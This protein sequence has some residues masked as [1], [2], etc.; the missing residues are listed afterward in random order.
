MEVFRVNR[1]IAHLIVLQRIELAGLF[2]KKLR[3]LF[4]RYIYSNFISKYFININ[5]VGEKYY[6][7]MQNE[8]KKIHNYLKPG[9][10]ILSVGAGIGGLEILI[11]QNNLNTK[12][13]FVEKNYISKKI[14]YGWDKNN[15]EAYNS[16]N[17]M[18]KFLVDNNVK[19]ET[20]QI[21]D[22]D[23]DELPKEKFD[24]II[25]LYS[26]DFHYDFELYR[27]YFQQVSTQE[28]VIIFDTIRPEY[29]EKIFKKG[30]IIQTDKNTVHKSKRIACKY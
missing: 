27:K 11:L 1:N 26:L 8:Y 9:Q 15:N 6:K 25:S 30:K 5:K 7:L 24:V 2:L 4:G 12:I 29:F 18:D 14:V 3:K 17:L 10:N 28:T 19:K 21:F 20:F 23:E 22:F 13:S 16:L